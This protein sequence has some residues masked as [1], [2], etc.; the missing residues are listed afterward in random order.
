MLI[1]KRILI[2]EDN[3]DLR[4]ILQWHIKHQG[5]DT[6][7]A[8]NG[9]EAVDLATSQVPDLI[10]MDMMM[11]V[12]DGHQATRMIRKHPS[13]YSTP[14]LAVTARVTM[15]DKEDCIQSGCDEFI[16]KP[17]TSIQLISSIAKLLDQNSKQPSTSPP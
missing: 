6:I 10:I 3:P 9:K 11:P 8:F 14:I 2:V 1:K 12:M 13:T 7:L 15:K 4:E 16:A 17:Y 5:Y